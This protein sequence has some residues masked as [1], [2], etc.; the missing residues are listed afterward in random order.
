MIIMIIA[1]TEGF[2]RRYPFF[3]QGH[4]DE[5]F[6]LEPH[7]HDKNIIVSAGHDGNIIIWDIST[8][9]LLKKYFNHVSKITLYNSFIF[10]DTSPIR[11]K[12]N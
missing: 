6:V 2:K 1:L 7:P 10:L 5:L 12:S 8:G 11:L 4:T 3:I 9:T